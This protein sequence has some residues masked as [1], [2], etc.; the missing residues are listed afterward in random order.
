MKLT[1]KK[2]IEKELCMLKFCT[3]IKAVENLLD[4]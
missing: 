2:V 4:W 3:N 1:E